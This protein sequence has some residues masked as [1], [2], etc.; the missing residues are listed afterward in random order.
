MPSSHT[1]TFK[2]FRKTF[3]KKETFLWEHKKLTD[4]KEKFKQILKH[5]LPASVVEE[6]AKTKEN[7]KLGI[8]NLSSLVQTLM[9][10]KHHLQKKNNWKK[11]KRKRQKRSQP[12]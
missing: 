10:F 9:L 5:V 8:G 2:Y 12:Q 6:F 7:N 4:E 3:L 11:K 1:Q